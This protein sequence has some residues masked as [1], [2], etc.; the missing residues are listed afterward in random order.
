M[1]SNVRAYIST[2]FLEILRLLNELYALSIDHELLYYELTLRLGLSLIGLMNKDL[3]CEIDAGS[4]D[5][6]LN[7]FDSFIIISVYCS[8]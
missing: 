1:F 2:V 5:H 7:T 8:M 4:E 6:S 3:S